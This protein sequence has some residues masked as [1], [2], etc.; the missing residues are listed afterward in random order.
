MI[1]IEEFQKRRQAFCARMVKNSV[2]ILPAANMVKRNADADYPYRQ[3]SNFLYLTGFKEPEA[4]LVLISTEEESHSVLFC[5]DRDPQL[6][7][8]TGLRLGPDQ[9]VSQLKLDAAYSITEMDSKLPGI[10]G[11]CSSLYCDLGENQTFD[12]KVLRWM[13]QLRATIRDRIEPPYQL[14]SPQYLLNELRLHKSDNELNIMTQAG[15]ITALAHKRAM[16]NCRPGI[17]ESRIEAE[18][19]HEF[20]IHGARWPAYTSIVGGGERA[21]ILHYTDNNQELCDG[22]LLLIDAG[23]ELAGYASD[24]TR[25]FPVNG[26]FSDAQKALYNV[27]LEAQLATIEDCK[28]GTPYDQLQH[29]ANRVL[30]EG[31]MNLGILIGELKE[32]IETGAAKPFTV[33]KIG[34]WL[35]LDVHDAGSYMADGKS[36]LLEPGMVTTVEPGIYISSECTQAPAQFRG[37]GIRIEDDVVITDNAPQI[38]TEDVPKEIDEIE[39]LMRA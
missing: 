3:N 10:L 12:Q 11:N 14:I 2:A 15:H 37:L 34:H 31:L 23:C 28:S 27:V 13:N 4:V 5:R 1:A 33:H 32:L 18:L 19:L 24:L 29:T 22:D 7:Q 8:W 17:S 35:G 21:C 16:M 38:L 25:T 39:R 36:R 20:A 30:T 26:H 9:A 6:E